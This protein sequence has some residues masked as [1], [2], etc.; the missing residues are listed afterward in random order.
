MIPEV[1]LVQTVQDQQKKDSIGL[2]S[3]FFAVTAR[4][5][6]LTQNYGTK[7]LDHALRRYY[8]DQRNTLVQGALS[9]LAKKFTS[10]PYEF[11]GKGQILAIVAYMPSGQPIT[12]MV[13]ATTYFRDVAQY[14]HFG[15]GWKAFWDRVLIDYWTQNFGAVVELIGPGDP[16]SPLIGAVTGL[17][18]LDS[19]RCFAT[20][21]YTYPIIYYSKITG[22]MHRMHRTRVY[23][24]VDMPDPDELLYG[25]GQCALYRAISIAQRQILMGRYVEQSLDDKPRP[26]IM[27]VSG[28]TSGE[29][30]K[31]VMLY[32]KEQQSDERPVW[33]NTLWFH[34][35]DPTTPVKIESV[36]FSQPP[37][38][39]SFIDYTDL[40]INALALAIGVDKQELWELGGGNLG[41]GQQSK[42][43]SQ[44]SR[45]KA[46]GDVLST[47]DRMMNIAVCPDFVDFT[48]K[49]K[50]E[51]ADKAQSEIDKAYMDIASQMASMGKFSDLEI[52][53][54]LADKSE[55]YSK[56][57]TNQTGV[58]EANDQD[59][60]QEVS[61]V[62]ATDATTAQSQ[63][64]AT[65]QGATKA[66]GATT[67]QFESQ[68]RSIVGRANERRISRPQYEIFMLSALNTAGKS[69]FIDGLRKGGIDELDDSDMQQV[70]GWL[71][72]Q[73]DY[74]SKLGNEIYS[75][76]LS[77]AQ[78]PQR[79]DM[80]V[81]KS[82]E[83]MY[84]A[85]LM[86]ADRNG[87]Y[88]WWMD[89]SKKNCNTCQR[90]SG[91]VHRLKE[92]FRRDLLP[93]SKKLECGG[94]ECGCKLRKSTAGAVGRF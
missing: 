25:S 4:G 29:R 64:Q 52:R 23:R 59:Q 11:T 38:K 46:F 76:G 39:F 13:D 37:D 55:T 71:V 94:W 79:A 87:L 72:D 19:L 74:I 18:H 60:V 7:Q 54:M 83:E 91:Q 82:V 45:G 86:S 32:D 33:G 2:A 85:G 89:P 93:K 92:Y 27:A 40:D 20:G 69:A 53:N 61:E 22:K 43:L 58:V 67:A 24:M 9:G 17:S 81:N 5:P 8:R 1:A 10:A 41:S 34:S 80:W 62:T 51:D 66:Y 6:I 73:I 14:A 68:F 47:A 26:G 49:N 3:G 90:M 21:N 15:E 42:V 56:I 31:A 16:D 35:V 65:T 78:I 57:L 44:K 30:D 75:T 77:A 63:D 48:F 36:P 84:N 50:D 88:E 28:M 12:S 70:Q